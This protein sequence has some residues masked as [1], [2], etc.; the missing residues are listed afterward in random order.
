M[1]GYLKQNIV[2]DAMI[3]ILKVRVRLLLTIVYMK[4]HIYIVFL[5]FNC[6]S[7]VIIYQIC[8]CMKTKHKLLFFITSQNKK[9]L[10][11]FFIIVCI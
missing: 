2:H 1:Q 8:T 6:V 11:L 10:Y 3:L 4:A 9:V 7:L 5:S